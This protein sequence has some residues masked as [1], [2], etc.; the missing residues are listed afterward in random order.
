MAPHQGRGQARSRAGRRRGRGRGRRAAELPADCRFYRDIELIRG[1]LLVGNELVEAGRW[2]DALP[3]FLHPEEEIYSGLREGLKTYKVSPFLTA[4]KALT[5]TVKAKNKEAYRARPR[6]RRRAPRRR[7]GGVRA[8]AGGRGG[9]RGRDGAR[10][11]AGRRPTS[12]RRRSR[13]AASPTSSSTRT[14]AASCSRAERLVGTHAQALSAKNADAVK[15]VQASLG[16]LKGAFP[17]ADAAEDSRC[18]MWRQFLARSR[19]SSCSSASFR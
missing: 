9:L 19:R 11:A 14:P 5:Q 3:H 10:G 6:G 16:D 4:L 13:R 17:A 12:T 2:A 18:G 7:R 1:H 15:A 8:K